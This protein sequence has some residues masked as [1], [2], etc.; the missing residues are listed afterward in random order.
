[1]VDSICA[2]VRSFAAGAEPADDLTVLALRWNGSR[3]ATA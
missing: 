1:V 3:A 2:D